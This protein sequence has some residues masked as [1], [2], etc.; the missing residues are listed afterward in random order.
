[1]RAVREKIP[2]PVTNE[3]PR[4]KAATVCDV[5]DRYVQDAKKLFLEAPALFEKVKVGTLKLPAAMAALKR[6][7]EDPAAWSQLL[8]GAISVDDFNARFKKEAARLQRKR[9][10]RKDAQPASSDER[11]I[12]CPMCRGHGWI[13]R[14][15]LE[16]YVPEVL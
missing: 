11:G 6:K 4:E 1:M 8:E 2:E 16:G 3:R 9:R 13:A 10:A 5:N 7:L 15:K 12:S 14:E